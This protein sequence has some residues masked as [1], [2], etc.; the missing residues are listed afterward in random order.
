MNNEHHTEI[1]TELEACR[2][3][4]AGDREAMKACADAV[5]EQ[6]GI[7]RPERPSRHER[8][9]GHGRHAHIRE[10]LE[11]CLELDDI[12]ELKTCVREQI[13]N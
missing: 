5:F 13:D 1:R 11:A 12:D 2:E 10:E 6:Y 4:N 8:R 9:M 3:D 7:E